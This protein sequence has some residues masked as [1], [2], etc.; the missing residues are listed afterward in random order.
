MVRINLA[1]TAPINPTGATPVLTREQVWKGL[2]RKVRYAQE[3]V[4]P[5]T[6]CKVVREEGVEVERDVSFKADAGQGGD[7]VKEIVRL[8]EPC[9]VDFARPKDGSLVCNT[10]SDGPSG[11]DNDLQMTYSFQLI[12][13]DIQ[14]G[15][16]AKIAEVMKQQ[17]GMAKM[18]VESSIQTIR[19]MVKDGRIK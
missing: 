13:P 19:D 17:K 7:V 12:Y 15:D 6:A 4:A 1:Y 3:F 5:I 10:V 14:E 16:S 18:A 8:Y 11:T 2:E 9:K